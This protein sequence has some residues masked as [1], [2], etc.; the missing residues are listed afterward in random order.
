MLNKNESHE[1]KT[2]MVKKFGVRSGLCSEESAGST[3]M[4]W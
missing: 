4:D 3:V 1:W 2:R